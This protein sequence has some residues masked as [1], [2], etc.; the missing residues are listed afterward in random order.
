MSEKDSYYLI[1][2]ALRHH[3]RR[4]ILRRLSSHSTTFS[5]LLAELGIKSGHLCY[6]LKAMSPLL[7]R[8]QDG[9]YELSKDGKVA[10]NIM[11]RMEEATSPISYRLRR[12]QAKSIL[13]L[14]LVVLCLLGLTIYEFSEMSTLRADIIG[15]K[16]ELE[17]IRDI[18][19]YSKEYTC[20]SALEEL[21]PREIRINDVREMDAA[22][23]VGPPGRL[24]VEAEVFGGFLY[25]LEVRKGGVVLEISIRFSDQ[26]AGDKIG[27]VALFNEK[28]PSDYL[29]RESFSSSGTLS[30]SLPSP[31]RYLLAMNFVIES[32]LSNI[33]GDTLSTLTGLRLVRTAEVPSGPI[34][35]IGLTSPSLTGTIL[36]GSPDAASLKVICL[37]SQ[38][39]AQHCGGAVPFPTE[40]IRIGPDHRGMGLIPTVG[41]DL[42]V[43]V[44]KGGLPVSFW[45]TIE[46]S[47]LYLDHP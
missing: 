29:Y 10:F 18:L 46:R 33:S 42:E 44:V 34:S 16:D 1:G 40:W 37:F 41:C 13:S 8:S 32:V 24:E 5:E 4:V 26:F 21:E 2:S 43:K 22:Q 28:D 27:I 36:I 23:F 14:S 6:H 17:S 15:L 39:E 11:K 35:P 25:L 47:C 19:L 9:T 38:Q 30:W 45:M 31:G 20:F 7:A 3:I 12:P